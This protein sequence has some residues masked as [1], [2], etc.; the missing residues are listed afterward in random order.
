MAGG[1]REEHPERFLVDVEEEKLRAQA[2]LALVDAAPGAIDEL[3]ADRGLPLICARLLRAMDCTTAVLSLVDYRHDTL[4]SVAGYDLSGVRTAVRGSRAL[5]SDPTAARVIG[6]REPLFATPDPGPPGPDRPG[7]PA[8][9]TEGGWLALPLVLRGESIGM[10]ELL[11]GHRERR[12]STAELVLAQGVC[13]VIAQAAADS[14]AF[15][16][17]RP[18]VEPASD[19]EG[20]GAAGRAPG[21]GWSNIRWSTSPGDSPRASRSSTATSSSA[22]KRRGRPRWSLTTSPPTPPDRPP[23]RSSALGD[24]GA[25]ARAAAERRI[26]SAHDDDLELSAEERAEMVA[27]GQRA[28]MYVPIV[29]GGEV[30][31]FLCAIERRHSRR[32]TKSDEAFATRLADEA[33]VAVESARAIDRLDTR[34]AELRLLLETGAAIASSVD[35]RTTLSRSTNDSSRRSVSPGRTSTTTMPTR[36]S[37]R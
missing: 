4:E 31:G 26:A 34:T 20:D 32:F 12:Y 18:P 19:D 24:S 28:V 25:R 27:R 15:A 33:G 23:D 21:G 3:G 17:Y 6:N 8:A 22:R 9:Q 11:A 2:L 30:V 7:G 5:A 14:L 36:T 35:L 13:A 10:I 1:P 29:V 37:S 16:R